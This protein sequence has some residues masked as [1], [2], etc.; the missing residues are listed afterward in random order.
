[1]E[2]TGGDELR[3]EE[4]PKRREEREREARRRNREKRERK[5]KRQKWKRKKAWKDILDRDITRTF[6][7][8]YTSNAPFKL[9]TKCSPKF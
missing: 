9:R 7:P 4:G 6:Y 1:M 5:K 2:L 8:C 3:K